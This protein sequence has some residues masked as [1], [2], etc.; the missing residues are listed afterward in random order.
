MFHSSTYF[1]F[2]SHDT[3]ALKHCGFD[4]HGIT[5]KYNYSVKQEITLYAKY[6]VP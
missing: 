5:Q 3:Q 1:T 4:I 2:I 6:N